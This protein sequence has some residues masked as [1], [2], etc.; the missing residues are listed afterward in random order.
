MHMDAIL[1]ITA[2]LQANMDAKLATDKLQL[3]DDVQ[4]EFPDISR[5]TLV[6][7]IEHAVAT[8]GGAAV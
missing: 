5:Q 3:A 6:E 7:L 2:I 4:A 1:R 8:I